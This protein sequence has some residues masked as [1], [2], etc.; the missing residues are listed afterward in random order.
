MYTLS[1]KN[2]SSNRYAYITDWALNV[3]VVIFSESGIP[4]LSTLAL[5]YTPEHSEATSFE[6]LSFLV[7]DI[8]TGDGKFYLYETGPITL[9]VNRPICY[10]LIAIRAT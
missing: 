1:T 2:L 6:E 5:G 10:P 4:I 3:R 8:T 9:E 7:T